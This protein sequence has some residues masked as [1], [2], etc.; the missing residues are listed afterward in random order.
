[1]CCFFFC[2]AVLVANVTVERMWVLAL[3]LKAFHGY[4]KSLVTK[5][6]MLQIIRHGVIRLVI[7]LACGGTGFSKQWL[8]RDLEVLQ[9]F[10]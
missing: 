6:G 4:L 10:E 8:L 7:R 2:T 9:A 1:M 3:A 5:E